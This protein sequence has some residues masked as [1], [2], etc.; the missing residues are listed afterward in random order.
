MQQC[1]IKNPVFQTLPGA[2]GVN[3]MSRGN[4]IRFTTSQDICSGRFCIYFSRELLILDYV[5]IH[6][7]KESLIRGYNVDVGV[8]E[9]F[10][11]DKEGKRVRKQLEVD[12][13][14]N[15]GN[16]RYYI[17]AAYDMTS[18]EKQTQ[19]FYSLRNIPDSFKRIVIVNGTKKPWR[20][21]TLQ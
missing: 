16:K 8:V 5:Q 18:E 10:D 19:E 17:Q 15:Q 4:S 11:K 14:A 6:K 9:I 2:L 21:C 13:V 1:Y 7:N 12:F 20:K 3:Q